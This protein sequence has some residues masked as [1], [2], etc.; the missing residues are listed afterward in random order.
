MSAP[1]DPMDW[2]AAELARAIR[3]RK[4]SACEYT[5]AFEAAC[6][7]HADLHAYISHDFDRLQD[8]ASAVDR[9]ASTGALLGVPVA[10]KDNIDTVDLPTTGGTPTLKGNRPPKNAPVMDRLFGAGA[11]LAGKLNMHELAYGGTNDNL[12]FGRALN[13]FDRTRTAGGSSGGSAV[14]VAARLA[15]A[16]LGSDTAGSIRVPAALCGIYGFRPTL[17]RYPGAGVI[18][19]AH[20]R[21]T[22]G[23]MARSLDDIALL[24]SILANDPTPVAPPPVSSIRIGLDRER[25]FNAASSP[26]QNVLERL[27]DVWR[28]AGVTFIDV[29]ITRDAETYQFVTG[30]VI[31]YEYIPDFET[32]LAASAP[33]VRFTDVMAGAAS[34][35]LRSHLAKRWDRRGA[36]SAADYA[37]AIGPDLAAL[38]AAYASVFARHQLSAILMPAT[39]DVALPFAGDDNVLKDNT[40]ISSW[41]YFR[42]TSHATVLGTPS[43]AIPAGSDPNGLP[44]GA[45][46]DGLPGRDREL[47]AVAMTLDSH[48]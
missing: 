16:A 4:I 1:S 33:Q 17:H 3:D 48:T 30:T 39:L 41:F 18:P 28:R 42:H 7:T 13:P 47:I 14:A 12:A 26:I 8:A 38:R 19:I 44:I 46:L 21:D 37:R 36:T 23:P 6:R 29:E 11:L 40:A 25:F 32:Y 24:D 5:A 22:V 27:I 2:G 43:L 31:E 35:I 45:L 10:I 34:P 15:P 20:G 9:S